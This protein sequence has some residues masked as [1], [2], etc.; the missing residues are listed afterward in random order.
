[1]EVSKV[2]EA[3]RAAGAEVIVISFEP[4]ARL[5]LYIEAHRWPFP[6]VSDP[7]LLAYRAFGLGAAGWL[8]LFRP[9]VIL[10]YLG[11]I[12][13]GYR[14]EPSGADVHQLGGDFVI[15]SSRHLLFEHRST[16]P[17]DR[18]SAQALLR[19]LPKPSAG[20]P[21]GDGKSS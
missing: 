2:Y 1:M 15:D 13:R 16:D 4:P 11:L 7:D 8:T 12:A 3:V 20:R 19:A 17:A 21:G 18:P 9:G 6:V 14:P 10:K 5:P